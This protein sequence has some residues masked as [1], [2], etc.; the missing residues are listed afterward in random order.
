MNMTAIDRIRR[1]ILLAALA[2][3]MTLTPRPA[4][5]QATDVNYDEAR[6]PAYTLPDPLRTEEGGVVRTP[7]D[8]WEGRRPEI[9][10]LFESEMFGRAPATPT[11][12]SFELR[13]EDDAALNGA[14]TRKE[15]RIR[16]G[17]A[18]DA[19]GM[20]LLLF[21]P[22]GRELPVPVVLALNFR[23]NHT[24]HPD[25]GITPAE[26]VSLAEH[27][28]GAA[29]G[30]WPL[31]T[32]IGRGYGLATI[33]YGDIDPDFDDGF[34]NGVHPMFYREGQE[35]PAPD[36]WAS[37]AAWAWGLSRA[38]DY[39][40]TDPDVIEEEV[41]VMGHSRLGKTALWAGALDTRFGFVISNNSGAGGAALSRRRFGETV[42]HLN[43]R[44][45]HWFAGNFHAFSGRED[46]MPF[47]QHMLLALI[48]PRPLYVASAV[49]DTW[50]DPRG[51]FLS[52]LHA[53]PVYRLLSGEGLD[54]NEMP[55]IEEPVMSRV[56][57]HIRRGEHDVT[58]YDWERWL[59]WMDSLR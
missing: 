43:E 29:A 48:A 26:G 5:G 31:E 39:L 17:D 47:D 45:P 9:L 15:I 51:E 38:M 12:P 55:G 6:V 13:S 42:A 59:D 50:A 49:E 34:Q 14:A 22:R 23:G 7:E 27:P 25:A 16:L 37:I 36:E 1:R 41:A 11:A 4:S 40:E 52:A 30:R 28:R 20:D 10:R 53:D 3:G 58:L 19:P 44:F 2:L 56:G 21:I 32:I 8:W 24:I 18:V 46:E 35:R 57:Y 33:Y 54:A